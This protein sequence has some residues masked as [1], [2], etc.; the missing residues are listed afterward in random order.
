MMGGFAARVVAGLQELVEV[1][2]DPDAGDAAVLDVRPTD[3]GEGLD[4]PVGE[5]L[6]PAP[7]RLALAPDAEAPLIPVLSDVRG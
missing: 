7:G 6:L 1:D 3:D 5:V 2:G 4:I